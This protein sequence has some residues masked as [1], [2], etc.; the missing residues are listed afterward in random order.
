MLMAIVIYMAERIFILLA[1]GCTETKQQ[2]GE[3]LQKPSCCILSSQFLSLE[4][5]KVCN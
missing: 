4:V 2:H 3:T 5:D 1:C